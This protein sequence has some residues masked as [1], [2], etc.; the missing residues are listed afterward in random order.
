MS[1]DFDA[2][3]K[4][5]GP[6]CYRLGLA[7]PLFVVP[8]PDPVRLRGLT[9]TEL[10][11]LARYRRAATEALEA[12]DEAAGDR[13]AAIESL[14]DPWW[15]ELR[16]AMLRRGWSPQEHIHGLARICTKDLDDWLP[17]ISGFHAFGAPHQIHISNFSELWGMKPIA[18]T[19]DG[20]VV[21]GYG[22][23]GPPKEL[24]WQ[25]G[26]V[27]PI[28]DTRTDDRPGRALLAPGL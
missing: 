18:N 14:E 11:E 24:P 26:S 12:Y 25:T 10:D 7:E 13:L 19:A 23:E 1:D 4:R 16:P 6:P 28:V 17:A 8:Q 5:P 15:T 21:Y 3:A 9:E 22:E 2:A 27:R 20:G